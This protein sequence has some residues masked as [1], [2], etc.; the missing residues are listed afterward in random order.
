MI[1]SHSR[2]FIFLKPMKV[3]GTSLEI[4]LSKFCGPQ[5]VLTPFG[6]K[7]EGLRRSLGYAGERNHH[8]PR[9]RYSRKDWA[10][11]L[12]TRRRPRL[13]F[14]HD[15]AEK[16]RDTLP[17]EVWETFLKVTVVRNPFDYAVSRY[18]WEQRLGALPDFE[19]WLLATPEVLLTNRRITHID[20]RPVADVTLRYERLAPDLTALSERLGLEE[21]LAQVMKGIRT[22]ATERP[23]QARA[24]ELFATRPRARALVELVCAEEI[25]RYGYASP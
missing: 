21:D 5:D 19:A 17:K 1:I 7:D 6:K 25:E 13:Y 14:G 11:R 2:G 18:Y 4:A 10:R 12:A 15:P 22:K 9:A 20:G 3:A 23:R 24:P 8:L 16:I